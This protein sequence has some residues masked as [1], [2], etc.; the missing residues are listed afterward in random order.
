[1]LSYCRWK[2]PNNSRYYIAHVQRDLLG[3][4]VVV[5][6]WGKK[7]TNLGRLKTVFCETEKKVL[8]YLKKLNRARVRHGYIEIITESLKDRR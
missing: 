1:M 7:E 4:W 5:I 6:C 8:G 3:D 2:N